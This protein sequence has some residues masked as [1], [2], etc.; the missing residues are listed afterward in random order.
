MKNINLTKQQMG[1]AIAALIVLCG[2]SFFAGTKVGRVGQNDAQNQVGARFAQGGSRMMR[3]GANA[4]IINGAILSKDDKSITVQL[5]DGGSKIVFLSS[6][7]T[8]AKAVNGS[9]SDL[10]VGQQVMVN[11]TANPDGSVTAQNIQV[12]PNTPEPRV[13]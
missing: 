2:G 11:G 5:R 13:R 6:A 12:R 9:M 1:I 8:I 4:G 3:G 7:A 10:T